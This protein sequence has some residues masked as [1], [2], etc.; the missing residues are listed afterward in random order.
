[1]LGTVLLLVFTAQ[2][3]A[4]DS[5]T[6]EVRQLVTFKFQPG[7]TGAA[8]ALFRDQALPLYR[9]NQP[10][11]SFSGFREVE[12]P[13]SLDLIVVS[14]FR[15]MAGMDESNA[16]LGAEA[17]RAG[18]TVGAIYGGIGALSTSHRDEFVEMLA[19]LTN[20]DPTTSRLVALISYQLLPGEGPG[21]ESH[22][23]GTLVGWE[24]GAGIS[25]AT[26][27]YLISDG[28]ALLALPRLR[29][30]GRLPRVLV[31]RGIGGGV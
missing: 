11:L 12:S 26:G 29:F 10:M 2:A 24:K 20:G 16:A 22:L 17:E 28:W 8:I 9:R 5:T 4:Q 25:S 13:E 1:M 23:R 6:R 19:P 18:T 14:A 7:K 15:G 30:V 31:G 21:F 3:D 27:R